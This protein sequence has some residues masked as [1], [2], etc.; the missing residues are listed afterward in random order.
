MAGRKTTNRTT[1]DTNLALDFQFVDE[2][3]HYVLSVALALVGA[4][5]LAEAARRLSV[6]TIVPA[7]HI[8]VAL[9]EEVEPVGV[10]T[11]DH[12]LVVERIGVA[13]YYR[14]LAQVLGLFQ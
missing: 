13:H 4:D 10:G 8:D 12:L 14:G 7:E 3:S 5:G 1:I 6:T 9:E 2:E 11:R